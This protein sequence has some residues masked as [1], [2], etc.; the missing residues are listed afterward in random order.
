MLAI[1][2]KKMHFVFSF[3]NLY[4]SWVNWIISL[5]IREHIKLIFF[6]F[7]TT[8]FHQTVKTVKQQAKTSFSEWEVNFTW[9][10]I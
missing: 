4:K 9:H 10:V 7:H 3:I 2:A 5:A 6:G 8:V 1:N